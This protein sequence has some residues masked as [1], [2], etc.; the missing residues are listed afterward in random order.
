MG[1]E[2]STTH[3]A[4]LE[5][6][7][8]SLFGNEPYYPVDTDWGEVVKE[9]KA[10]TVLGI[11]SPVIPAKDVSVEMGKAI[12]MRLLFEQDKLI[13]LLDVNDI[14]CVILKGSA[15]AQYYPKPHLRAMGDVDFLVSHDKFYE[16]AKVLEDNGYKYEHGKDESGSRPEYVRH[17]SYSKN[18]I[19]FELHHH[20]SSPGYCI[21]DILEKAINNR[22]YRDLD[23]YKIPVLPYIENGLVFLGHINHHLKFG[24]LGLRQIIDWEMYFQSELNKT[25]WNDSFVPV[26]EKVGF[27][28]LAINV[29]RMCNKFLGLPE[30]V[31]FGNRSNE[32][33]SDILLD[34]L[35]ENG[36][37]GVKTRGTSQMKNG[38]VVSFGIYNI[39]KN[40]FFSYF[41]DMGLRKW[42]LC[43]K[44]PILRPFAWIYGICRAIVGGTASIIKYGNVKDQI[45]EGKEKYDLFEKLGIEASSK[46][47]K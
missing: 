25:K 27:E 15:A 6:I 8:A 9:A 5:A 43:R 36:N 19:E 2:L 7:K 31:D 12:Y 22:E 40:G 30:T 20:F 11:I 29:T 28:K 4:L 45:C 24:D 42:S 23:G 35:F 10:Q 21:D 26:V 32:D 38:G 46:S 33:V 1:T 34:M 14:P 17:F 44:Y 41:Q 37:F 13:K 16:A 18:G 39:K 3:I 47:L